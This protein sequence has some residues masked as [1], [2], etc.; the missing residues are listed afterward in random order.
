[1]LASRKRLESAPLENGVTKTLFGEIAATL[2]LS[3]PIVLTNV[4]VNFMTTTDVMF[5][6]RLSPDALAAGALGFNCY[7]PPFLFCVGVVSAAAPLAAERIGHDRRDVAGVRTVGH[8]ALLSALLLCLPFWALFWNAGRLLGALGEPPAL[9][10]L[11]GTYM[12]GLQWAL[13]PA[14]LYMA[15]RSTLAALN[16]VRPVLAAGLIAVGANALFNYALVF[17]HFGLPALGAFGSGLSTTLSQALMF[18]LLVGYSVL[19]PKLRPH[20]LMTSRWRF[21]RHAFAALWRL[22]G[23]IGF[24]IAL[25]VATF[26]VSALAMGL[27]GAPQLEAHTVA[28]NIAATAFMVPLG[29]G[30]AATVRVGHAFGARDPAGVSRAGWTALAMAMAFVAASALTM[31]LAP[32]LLI[33][34][35]LDPNDPRNAPTLG[36]AVAFVRMAGVFQLADGAQAALSNMLRGV[37]DSRVPLAMALLGYWGIGAPAGFALAFLT[38][39]GGLGLWIGMALGLTA[40]AAMLYARWRA[41]E[42]QGF[43]QPA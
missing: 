24:F 19:D 21:E 28:L 42:R 41:K 5:L 40:V 14:L 16:R 8:Q 23:P 10:S 13:L 27:I 12:H 1:M 38:P 11:A 39:L 25:E 7:M 17:G 15:A 2:A 20:K 4:A 18:A 9:A 22:G 37:H 3:W 31:A 43:P 36:Y 26:A 34:A 6:G 33:S 29:L 30:M 35:F 32:R